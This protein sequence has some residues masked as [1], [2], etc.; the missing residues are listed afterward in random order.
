MAS[1]FASL[2]VNSGSTTS[3]GMSMTRSPSGRTTSSRNAASTSAWSK[4][5]PGL[6]GITRGLP[7]SSRISASTGSAPSPETSLASCL[8]SLLGRSRGSSRPSSG[9]RLSARAYWRGFSATSDVAEAERD[10]AR[11]GRRGELVDRRLHVVGVD[12]GRHLRQRQLDGRIV[13]CEVRRHEGLAGRVGVQLRP[14]RGLRH[15]DALRA[16]RDRTVH[17]LGPHGRHRDRPGRTS[18]PRRRSTTTGSISSPPVAYDHSHAG[19]Q[20]LRAPASATE[21]V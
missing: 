2:V 16:E 20:L 18:T 5:T 7:A 13:R 11:H 9:T 19:L 14:D 21:A 15:V 4:L 17:R 1:A 12:V 8:A 10:R 3:A 6:A